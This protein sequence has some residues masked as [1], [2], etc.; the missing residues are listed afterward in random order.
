[1]IANL[2]RAARDGEVV[3]I[4]GGQ[5]NRDEIAAFLRTIKE[6][7]DVVEQAHAAFG[8]LACKAAKED[9]AE[10]KDREARAWRVLNQLKGA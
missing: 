10:F 7:T 5:F 8:Y 9:K 1:M 3:T 2:K 6:A 4:G